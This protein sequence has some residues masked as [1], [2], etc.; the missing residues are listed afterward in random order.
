MEVLLNLVVLLKKQFQDK[1]KLTTLEGKLY[2]E[3]YKELSDEAAQNEIESEFPKPEIHRRNTG[4]AV[5]ELLWSNTFW[6]RD[7]DFNFCN[8]LSGSEGT[9]AFTTEITL[10]LDDLPPTEA[11]MVASHYKSI[12]DCLNDVEN[13]MKHNLYTCEM[14]DKIILDCTKNNTT[15]AK[16]RFFIEG[17]PAAI[18]MLEIKAYS[19][20]EAKEKHNY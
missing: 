7:R 4:Y 2:Q 12:D 10:Q 14:M 11:V 1:L 19:I 8:L 15:Q 9:L 18:L 5:D 13:T 6:K 3:I 16:N 20:E 17:D